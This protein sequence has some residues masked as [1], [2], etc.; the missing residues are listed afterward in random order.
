MARDT[1]VLNICVRNVSFPSTH[2]AANAAAKIKMIKYARL[3]TSHHGNGIVDGG[4][5]VVT[6]SAMNTLYHLSL[7]MYR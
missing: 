5:G 1:A 7:F 4:I 2:D 3:G 6:G